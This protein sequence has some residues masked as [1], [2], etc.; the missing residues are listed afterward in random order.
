MEQEMGRRIRNNH[1]WKNRGFINSFS[2]L[3]LRWLK[4][5][6]II[7]DNEAKLFDPP[8][9]GCGLA[10]ADLRHE[11]GYRNRLVL[12]GRGV[13]QT[14]GLIYKPT[15][16]G[17]RR[18]YMLD[19]NECPREVLYLLKDYFV[20]RT[21]SLLNY[22]SQSSPKWARLNL[23]R[24]KI[25]QKLE[26]SSLKGPAR[27]ANKDRLRAELDEIEDQIAWTLECDGA[28]LIQRIV[29]GR[30]VRRTRR[31]LSQQRL[32]I[33]RKAL[34][35]NEMRAS[36]EWIAG[37]FG[38]LLDQCKAGDRPTRGSE[39]KAENSKTRKS[40]PTA[41][42]DLGLLRR[43]GNW[44]PGE[45]VGDELGWPPAWIQSE[46]RRLY[47]LIDLRVAGREC[48]IFIVQD[49]GQPPRAQFFWLREGLGAFGR[50]QWFFWDPASHKASDRLRYGRN[51]FR[52]HDAEQ[53]SDDD[54]NFA[55]A[56]AETEQ[57]IPKPK[58]Y[59]GYQ[60]GDIKI[61]PAR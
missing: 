30:N 22:S 2:T 16:F 32:E 44:K 5:V 52:Y 45:L 20:S 19:E 10:L 61:R 28:P 8:L 12:R 13:E 48:A 31:Q 54:W 29:S 6:G 1:A 46:G 4:R 35:F 25:K 38:N 9:F 27:G 51:G 26:G 57:W 23:R 7:K 21:K 37:R 11:A 47:F 58:V 39:I 53:P 3:D 17:G 15:R 40:L 14:I 34:R 59:A 43:L 33:F 18:W 36:A 50:R 55:L 60:D 41:E 24:E 49:E 42:I 56:A